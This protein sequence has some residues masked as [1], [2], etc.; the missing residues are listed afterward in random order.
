MPRRT[1]IKSRRLNQ[2]IET[3]TNFI[4][5]ARPEL[6][7]DEARELATKMLVD[8]TDEFLEMMRSV[9]WLYRPRKVLKADDERHGTV[10]AYT[11]YGCRCPA[12]KE[13]NV[14]ASNRRRVD[15]EARGLPPDDDRHGTY[16]AYTNYNCRCDA[17][18]LAARDRYV[19]DPR[20]GRVR[21]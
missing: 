16:N 11:N 9:V 10:N 18:K 19:G 13:A 3:L 1:A 8:P 15:R 20:D 2:H 14:I 6:S 17:C 4:K 21:H 7:I 12:C 5:D